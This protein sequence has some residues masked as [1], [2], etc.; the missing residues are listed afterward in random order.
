[1]VIPSLA[2]G[3]WAQAVDW[4]HVGESDSEQEMGADA[5][6]ARRKTRKE[7]RGLSSG[8]LASGRTCWNDVLSETSL[9]DSGTPCGTASRPVPWLFKSMQSESYV[10]VGARRIIPTYYY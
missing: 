5:S 6:G 8:H 2:Y 10:V 7:R 1:M 4:S 9:S 3:M